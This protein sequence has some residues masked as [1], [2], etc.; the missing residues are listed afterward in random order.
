MRKSAGQTLFGTINVHS[1]SIDRDF[2]HTVVWNVLL[3]MLAEVAKNYQLSCSD[4]T[5][6]DMLIHHSRDTPEKQWSETVV[7]SLNG[8]AKIF[9][10]FKDSLFAIADFERVWGVLMTHVT[11]ACCYKNAEIAMTAVKCLSDLGDT[12]ASK[13]AGE[14]LWAPLWVAWVKVGRDLLCPPA[15]SVYLPT[16]Q[17]LTVY[18]KL[19]LPIFTNLR[20]GFKQ[21][22]LESFASHICLTLTVPMPSDSTAIF[23]LAPSAGPN[24]PEGN[25]SQLQSSIVALLNSLAKLVVEGEATL[26]PCF[27]CLLL[28]V[29]TFAC[30]LPKFAS[31]NTRLVDLTSPAPFRAANQA[32]QVRSDRC[33]R[34]LCSGGRCGV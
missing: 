33:A 6:T 3:H 1:P 27:Y 7:I 25:M 15:T 31:V 13:A 26:L 34:D 16:Q 9:S 5:K 10:A 17:F 18:S 30:E 19:F 29:S 11:S 8:I 28:R 12:L 21:A 20:A 24:A 32:Q 4:V 14:R 22:D 2:W 23:L